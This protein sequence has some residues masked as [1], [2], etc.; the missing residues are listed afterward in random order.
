MADQ[1]QILYNGIDAFAPQ[2][3]PLVAL[4]EQVIYADEIWGQAETMTLQGQLTGCSFNAIVDSQNTLLS[5]FNQSFQTLQ[6]WQTEGGISGKVFQ[7]EL[8]EVN[9]VQFDQSRWFGVLPYSINLTCYPSGLFSGTFGILNP[10]DNWTFAE[11]ENASLDVTHSISCQPFNTSSGPSNALNNARNWAFGR[12]GINTWVY[13]IMISGVSANNFCLLTQTETIDRFNGTYSL[14][15]N[16]TNDLA[17]TG[18]GVIRYSTDIASGDNHISVNLQGV[19]QGC[20]RNITGIRAAFNN[21]D[22]VAIALKQYQSAFNRTDLNP[23]PVAQSFNENPFTTEIAFSYA[24]DNSN[25]P[26][27]WFDYEVGLSIGTNGLISANIDGTVH[28]RG[29]DLTNKLIRTKAYAAT[30]NLYNLVLPFYT[31]FDASSSVALNPVPLSNGQVNNETNGT[32]SLN[33]S[34]NNRATTVSTLDQFNATINISPSLAQVDAQ[35][36]LNGLGTWSV[37]N[38]NYGRR[39]TLSVNGNAIVN[40]NS[41]AA[42]GEIAVRNAAYALFTQYGRFSNAILDRNEVTVSR[43]DERILSFNFAW[44]F[45]PTNIIGPTSVGSLIV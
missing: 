3:T 29:G 30:I 13:P 4:G 14:T 32:V 27:V 24:F 2:P 33:A 9:S 41:S 10:Q 42:A 1:V 11:Q 45:G 35:P 28:A 43:T 18:Y 17:R 7:K 12:T 39:A 6:I 8:V 44:S 20:S 5:R 34:Y 26:S 16:Y 37:V 38:L 40:R 19:A 31:P 21:L 15:E 25:L 22:K 23:I 36:V